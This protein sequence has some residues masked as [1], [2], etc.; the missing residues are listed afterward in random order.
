[1]PVADVA[2]RML[3]AYPRDFSV[4]RDV[5]ASPTAHCA[6]RCAPRSSASSSSPSRPHPSAATRDETCALT[7]L[8]LL[9][10]E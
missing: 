9:S 2:H 5:T 8:Q 4:D 1:M 6:G 10:D 3:D 7:C